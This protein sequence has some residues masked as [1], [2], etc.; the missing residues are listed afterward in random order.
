MAHTSISAARTEPAHHSK[1][2]QFQRADCELL[3]LS[4]LYVMPGSR[5]EVS[6]A[7]HTVHSNANPLSQLAALTLTSNASSV[8][9]YL[10]HLPP[11]RS[12]QHLDM[13]VPDYELLE[14]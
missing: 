8:S 13:T 4:I 2:L 9:W 14:S 1:P 11:T 5:T 3:D 7:E 10:T 6:H 12:L